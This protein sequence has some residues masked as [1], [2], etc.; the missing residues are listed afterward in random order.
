MR[1]STLTLFLAFLAP[2]LAR[3]LPPS[4][5]TCLG[6][7]TGDGA[8]APDLK[9]F[10]KSAHGKLDCVAC[11][12]DAADAPHAKKPGAVDC[13]RCHG[14]KGKA[15]SMPDGR[16]ALESYRLTVHG[17]AREAGNTAAAD[18]ANCHGSHNVRRP[19]DPASRVNKRNIAATCGACHTDEAKA[20]RASVHG[21]ALAKGAQE[22]PTCTDCHGEH[23][24]RSPSEPASSVWKGAV[25]KTCSGCHAS[26]R[27]QAKFGVPADRVHTFL[28][29]YHGLAGKSGDL[30]VANCASC[31]GWHDV[32]PAS[33]PRSR[34]NPANL[35]QT[36]GQCHPQATVSL[37]SGK[38][39]QALSGDGDGSRVASLLRLF[40]LIIIPMTIGGM[41]FHN[42][43]DLLR[44]AL[45]KAPLAHLKE[46]T[47]ELLMTVPERLQHGLLMTS[48]IALA[49]SG[50]ALKFPA[51]WP[52]GAEHSRLIVHRAAA[53]LFVV[54]GALHGGYLLLTP[55]GR[56]RL[57]ALLPARRDLFDPLKLFLYN[58]GLSSERPLLARWSYIEKAEYWALIWGSGVMVVTGAILIFHNYALAH[59]PLW[60]IESA[61]VVHF[62]EA[63]LACL[64]IL[65]WHGYWVVF[66][67]EVYPMSWAWLTG[68][69]RREDKKDG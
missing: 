55:M 30:S 46:E 18:C 67:P 53:L 35:A 69:A 63:T 50:L 16:P 37:T 41:L 23:T 4:A 6:C 61:R 10:E 68:K 39:H 66:D 33:D 22:A 57:S 7:H 42:G 5:E 19:S 36:C 21:K 40:Y 34:V 25:T 3:G 11:H 17:Q 58:L 54:L 20:Y 8:P 24:I 56:R 27:L 64:S 43:I 15:A 45:A 31:H 28:D 49:Y 32:L 14:V 2:A 26:E 48:F 12:A 29:S 44:H 65:C 59:F 60:V 38:V 47:S 52:T 51:L 9:G 62:M 1:I 13:G